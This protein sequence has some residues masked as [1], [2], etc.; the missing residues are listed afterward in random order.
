MV[1]TAL[2]KSLNLTHVLDFK[3]YGNVL[4][5]HENLLEILKFG[6]IIYSCFFTTTVMKV[7]VYFKET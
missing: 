2:E 3:M 6:I 1:C 4:E 7:C 5:F